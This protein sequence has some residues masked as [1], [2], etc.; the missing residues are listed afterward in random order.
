MGICISL[1]IILIYA[2]LHYLFPGKD[3]FDIIEICFGNCIGKAIIILF[4]CFVFEDN[5]ETLRNYSQ[6]V[7]TVALVKT[8]LLIIWIA[9]IILCVWI[10][11]EGIEVI[12]R[13]SSFL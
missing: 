3:L 9:T 10:V 6:F 13:W 11:K 12:G 8:P 2:R 7:N 4:T 1:C 5:A